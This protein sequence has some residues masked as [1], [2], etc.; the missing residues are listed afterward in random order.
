MIKQQNPHA[1]TEQEGEHHL[2]NCLFHGLT[3]NIQNAL[4]YMYNNT[5]SQY[6][7]LV[8]AARKAE[9][10]TPGSGVSKVRA[11]STV[12]ELDT[13]SKA[14]SSEPPYEAITQQIAYFMSA[15]TNQNTS[16]YQQNGARHNN[17]NGKFPNTKTQRSKKDQKD[18]HC[19]G[20]G[21]TGHEWR[22]CLTASQGI[23]LAFK[24][25]NRNLNGQWGRKDR[26]PVLSQP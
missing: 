22:D 24:L 18:M 11:K 14:N 5:H 10:E 8:M 9:T 20:C 25:A 7:K 3:S 13:Q 17:G 4:H 12:V 1:M 16:N 15:I 23:N 2:K 6:S 21:G 19:W 26:P